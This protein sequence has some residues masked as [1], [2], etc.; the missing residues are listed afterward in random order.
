MCL[1]TGCNIEARQLDSRDDIERLLGFAAPTAV[2]LVQLKQ[3]V[4]E[5][6]DRL[7]CEAPEIVDPLMLRVLA[8]RH[9]VVA[10]ALTLAE[11]WRRV[12]RLGGYIGRKS[13]GDPG[14]RTLWRGWQRLSDL[15]EG[16]RLVTPSPLNKSSG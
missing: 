12:A 4:H 7:A 1:K 2:R 11:F 13:D 16:A 9:K 8:L 3:V 14:W 6:P 5:T 15:T 10:A